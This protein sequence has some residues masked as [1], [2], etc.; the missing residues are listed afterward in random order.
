MRL[1]EPVPTF[2]KPPAPVSNPLN[3]VEELSAP[4]SK[5]SL[6]ETISTVPAPAREPTLVVPPVC[7]LKIPPASTVRAVDELRPEMFDGDSIERV[8]P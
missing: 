1:R 8:P 3:V 6:A 5:T 7:A 2:A 4:T